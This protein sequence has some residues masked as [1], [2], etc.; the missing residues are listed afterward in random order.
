MHDRPVIRIEP[1]K[2]WISLNPLELWQFRELVCC[3][4]W[5]DIKIRYKPKTLGAVWTNLQKL[6]TMLV[7]GL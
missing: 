1:L 7:L 3:L 4:T 2:G 5:R 6:L